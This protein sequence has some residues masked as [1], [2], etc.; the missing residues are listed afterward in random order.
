[1]GGGTP[2]GQ[3]TDPDGGGGVSPQLCHP[4]PAGA[5]TSKISK[6]DPN[7]RSD[8]AKKINEFQRKM[9]V[10]AIDRE[11][12]NNNMRRSKRLAELNRVYTTFVNLADLEDAHLQRKI[13]INTNIL[14]NIIVPKTFEKAMISR[15][16]PQW[17]KAVVEEL[18]GLHHT[19]CYTETNL[20]PG[21]KAIFSK[22]VL[23]IKTDSLGNIRKYKA[24][25][26]CRGDMLKSDEYNEVSSPVVSWTGIRTFLALTTLYNLIPLQLDINLAYLNSPFGGRRLHV[27]WGYLSRF[28]S[29]S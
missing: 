28:D 19:E 5:P 25:C 6:T 18:K 15:D 27:S 11:T 24:R 9:K 22:W 23:T 4:E 7:H 29:S 10:S 2:A 21:K 3:S 26:T 8:T 12:V 20:P 17:K 16:A 14:S 1:M 13:F